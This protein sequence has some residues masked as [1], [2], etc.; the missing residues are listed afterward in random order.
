MFFLLL[1]HAVAAP[2]AAV[3]A[4]DTKTYCRKIGDTVG[5]SYQIEETCRDEEAEALRKLTSR[6][7]PDRLL[8]C[9]RIGETVGGSYQ[10]METCVE[11]ET[12]SAARLK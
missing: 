8:R 12:E 2:I 10:I 5:G 11:Q 1:A 4:F 3:P 6:E 9:S 7:I